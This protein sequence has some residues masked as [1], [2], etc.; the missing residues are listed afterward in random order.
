M[1][2]VVSMD[3]FYVVVIQKVLVV[4]FCVALGWK[5]IKHMWSFL[6]VPKEPIRVLI[7]GAAGMFLFCFIHVSSLH[8]LCL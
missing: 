7:T 4:S 3:N 2:F 5:I 1:V 8:I 6:N